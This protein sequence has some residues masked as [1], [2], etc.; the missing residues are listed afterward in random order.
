MMPRLADFSSPVVRRWFAA[1]QRYRLA[2]LVALA[3]FVR[4]V[5]LAALPGI[6]DFVSSGAVHG[7][8]S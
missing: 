4:V 5:A 1:F 6:F 7:S 3:V 8:A 2:L